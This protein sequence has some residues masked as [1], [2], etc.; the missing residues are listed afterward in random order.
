MGTELLLG[1]ALGFV[2]LG[3]KRMHTMLAQVMRAKTEFD[4]ARRSITSQLA[5]E[6]ETAAR[7]KSSGS[8][9]Q[10]PGSDQ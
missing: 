10:S 2:I 1:V 8:G 7:Q 4:R 9:P 3:P 5:A 6:F